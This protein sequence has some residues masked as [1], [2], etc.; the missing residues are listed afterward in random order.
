MMSVKV[1]FKLRKMESMMKYTYIYYVRNIQ[2]ESFLTLII[3]RIRDH[4]RS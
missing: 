4:H 1:D 2:R 3:T